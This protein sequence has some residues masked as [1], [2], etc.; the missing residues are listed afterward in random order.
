[1][2]NQEERLSRKTNLGYGVGTLSEAGFYQFMNSF[3]L[4]FLTSVVGISPGIAGTITF[5]TVLAD[6]GGTM[7]IGHF[8]DNLQS[9]YG[10]RRPMILAAAFCTPCLF[11]AGFVTVRAALPVQF[12]YYVTIGILFWIAYSVYYIPY[13]AMGAEIAPDYND[14]IRLRSVSRFFSVLGTFLTTVVSLN[15]IQRMIRGGVSASGAWLTFS[16]VLSVLLG[17]SMFACWNATRGLEK[18]QAPTREKL[19][20]TAILRDFGQLMRLRVMSIL[21]LSKIAF[22]FSFTLYTAGL[23]FFM[24]YKLKLDGGATSAIYLFYTA[25]G[26]LMTPVILTLAV[27][28]DKRKQMM[29]AFLVTGF[30]GVFLLLCGVDQ[31][32]TALIWVFLFAFS[33]NTYWQ[34]SNAMF[35]DITEVDELV[36][37]KRREGSITSLQALW[38]TAITAVAFQVSGLVL[39]AAGFNAGAAVQ[40]EAAVAATEK[41]FILYPVMGFLLSAG[42]LAFYPMN[43]KRFE[44]VR[45]ALERK[46]KGQDYAMYQEELK[47]L[48]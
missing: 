25:L 4:I 12:A 19:H 40:P 43:R 38:G 22:M 5:L 2:T 46:R 10:R 18:G 20:L 15:A 35:Y 17:A 45:E 7:F 47:K 28:T 8:S 23:M 6:A 32:K 21:I 44:M 33:N 14:R 48:I 34:L 37:G 16:A 31:M 36:N 1:M 39:R 27:R 26:L 29:A 13:A 42:I 9:R 30:G 3:Q 11:A 24:Q 41:L